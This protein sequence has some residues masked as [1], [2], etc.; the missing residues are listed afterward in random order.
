[1]KF[2]L[3]IITGYRFFKIFTG[4]G[5]QGPSGTPYPNLGRVPILSPP[6]GGGFYKCCSGYCNFPVTDFVKPKLIS[7]STRNICKLDMSVP[8][9][10]TKLFQN[11]YF[12]RIPKLW[13]NLP[14]S[15]RSSISVSNFK[16]TLYDVHL[17]R[18]I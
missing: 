4:S 9:W 1:M 14:P 15:T 5:L 8:F 7:P 17:F 11:Y 13:S 12:N 10:R 6:R 16:S 2:D 3:K 18:Y